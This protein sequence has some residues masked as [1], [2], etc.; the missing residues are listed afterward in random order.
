MIGDVHGRNSPPS[1]LQSVAGST[2]APAQSAVKA[3]V[4]DVSAV[5]GSGPES[6]A[7]SGNASIDQLFEAGD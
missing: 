5:S 1:S 4:A 2:V 7:T 6:I 3:K